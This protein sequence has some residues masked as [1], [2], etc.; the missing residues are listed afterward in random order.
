MT[1]SMEH[2]QL[3]AWVRS[4]GYDNLTEWAEDSDF[5]RGEDGYWYRVDEPKNHRQPVNIVQACFDA[6]EASQGT[7]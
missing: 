5:T 7:P 4:N 1:I 6:M 3:L 2:T